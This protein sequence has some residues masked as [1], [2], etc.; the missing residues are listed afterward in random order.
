MGITPRAVYYL[1]ERLKTLRP[2]LFN[3]KSVHIKRKKPF[4][5][6]E[7]RHSQPKYQF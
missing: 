5:F 1:I 4:S 6:N 2:D 7:R 3:E